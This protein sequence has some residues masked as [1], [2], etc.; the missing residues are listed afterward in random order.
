MEMENQD[1]IDMVEEEAAPEQELS[2][3]ESI[4]LMKE[5][6]EEYWK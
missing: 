2:A 3:E 1:E 4:Q 5:K 6:L